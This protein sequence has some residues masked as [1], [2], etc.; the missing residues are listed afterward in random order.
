MRVRPRTLL[1]VAAVATVVVFAVV[2]DRL[3]ARGAR[4]YVELQEAAA[5]GRGDPVAVDEIMVPAV[6]HSVE[7]ASMWGAVV[8]GAGV[9]AAG[10]V[11][12]VGA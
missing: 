12:R 1:S 11:R 8:L 7:Q 4:Q 5:A 3:T 10:V 6:R 9:V 2:Q